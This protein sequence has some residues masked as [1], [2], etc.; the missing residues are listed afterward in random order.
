MTDLIDTIRDESGAIY[1]QPGSVTQ[2]QLNALYPEILN[3]S[4][5]KGGTKIDQPFPR[6]ALALVNELMK[7]KIAAIETDNRDKNKFIRSTYWFNPVTFFHN[8]LNSLSKT[9]YQDYQS[10]RNEIQ[11]LIDKQIKTFVLDTWNGVTVNKEKYLEY[12]KKLSE[13]E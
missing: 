7:K 6:T 11:V 10:Y 3:S 2:S 9:H 12:H 5:A 8:Q 1:E 4:A 13:N